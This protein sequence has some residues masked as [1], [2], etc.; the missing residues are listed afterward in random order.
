MKASG[1]AG[2]PLPALVLTFGVAGAISPP[3]RVATASS[4]DVW[5]GGASERNKIHVDCWLDPLRG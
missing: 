2:S 5:G 3:K 1:L 4:G